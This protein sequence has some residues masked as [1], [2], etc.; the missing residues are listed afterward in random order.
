VT[1]KGNVISC[2]ECGRQISMPMEPEPGGKQSL[3]ERV[4][5][6]AAQEG[7]TYTDQRHVCP[8]HG[9]GPT[10]SEEPT[11]IKPEAELF[12]PMD[13]PETHQPD[14]EHRGMRALA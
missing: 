8:E 4:R 11:P 1:I 5:V 12:G 6:D 10:V 13:Q 9:G 14:D 2:D 7:W 3:D